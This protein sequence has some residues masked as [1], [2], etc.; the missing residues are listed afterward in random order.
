MATVESWAREVSL[1]R[2]VVTKLERA[3]GLARSVEGIEHAQDKLTE[4]ID[5]F[6]KGDWS[7]LTLTEIKSAGRLI[8]TRAERLIAAEKLPAARAEMA[9]AREKLAEAQKKES[10]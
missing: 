2:R 7:D 3:A 6:A 1:C 4:A 5:V 8:A 10:A 9:R